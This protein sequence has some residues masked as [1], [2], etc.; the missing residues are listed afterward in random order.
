MPS[1]DLLLEVVVLPM[2][3]SGRVVVKAVGEVDAYSAPLLRAAI[4]IALRRRGLQTLIVNL[5]GIN[6]M[7]AAGATCLA[8]ADR[9]SRARGVRMVVSHRG[10]RALMRPLQLTGLLRLLAPESRAEPGMW[11]RPKV[12]GQAR[13]MTAVA[14]APRLRLTQLGAR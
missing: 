1:P 10:Q 5:C 7:G 12:P 9:R 14:A 8:M 3:D 13:P 6:F 2:D 11:P 4:M